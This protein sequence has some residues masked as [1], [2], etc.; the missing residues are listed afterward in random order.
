[1]NLPSR[2]VTW[3]KEEIRQ[4]RAVELAPLLQRRGIAL[5]DRG[6]G[7]VEPEPYK[8]V[9][10]KASYWRWPERDMAGNTIDFY[11]KV[12]GASF[13]DAMK[14]ITSGV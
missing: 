1:M 4:A 14:E 3:T 8:G 5:R 6:G 2:S 10:I 9:F 13:S 7:N 12:L 11:V